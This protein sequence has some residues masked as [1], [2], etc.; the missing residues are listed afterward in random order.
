APCKSS[1]HCGS[2]SWAEFGR[3]LVTGCPT[4]PNPRPPL[5]ATPAGRRMRHGASPPRPAVAERCEDLGLRANARVVDAAEVV[6]DPS[7]AR[8][9][10]YLADLGQG[11][12]HAVCLAADRADV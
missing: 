2:R 4:R 3:R 5:P 8:N 6:M 9:Q 12:D 10:L 11:F 1:G 7:V